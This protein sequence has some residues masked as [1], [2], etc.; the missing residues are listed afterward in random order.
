M[1][2]RYP[3]IVVNCIEEL[4][5]LDGDG[6]EI[7]VDTSLPNPNGVEY[8]NL[9]LVAKTDSIQCSI[10]LILLMGSRL[11]YLPQVVE[12]CNFFFSN[13]NPTLISSVSRPSIEL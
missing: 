1:D 7:P 3:K 10:S 11:S 13:S 5:T 6:D 4:P 12:C 9:Y 2:P 8:D